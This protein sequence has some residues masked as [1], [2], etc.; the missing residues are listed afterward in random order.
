MGDAHHEADVG[1]AEGPES[2]G[3]GVEETH[4]ADVVLLVQAHG[5]GW[6][7]QV[8][9]QPSEESAN[10]ASCIMLLV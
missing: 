8:G 9:A 2:R 10:L 5:C 4:P 6:A 3:V 1:S 7:G